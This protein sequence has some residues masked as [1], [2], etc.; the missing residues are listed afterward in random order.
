MDYGELFRLDG[1]TAL[2]VGA[3]SGI[4][5]AVAEGL[6]AFGAQ[7]HCADA[8]FDA[9]EAT[10]KALGGPAVAL[11][12]DLLDPAAVEEAARSLAAPDILVT[13]PSVNVRKRIVE[14]GVRIDGRG[15]KD[16]RPLSSEVG[17]L[18]S[19]H[20]SGLFQRGETQVLN[21]TTLPRGFHASAAE[22]VSRAASP[23]AKIHQ[24]RIGAIPEHLGQA[25]SS[26]QFRGTKKLRF[27]HAGSSARRDD[28][29]VCAKD[30]LSQ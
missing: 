16:I 30:S 9:A 23:A 21:V 14:E 5:A 28:P 17:V 8:R 18:P 1:R 6:A 12:L 2:V 27:L 13:T 25:A 22:E 11:A 3:G 29:W 4:G 26:G 19:V 24:A 15:T 7:V 10:A 20:G